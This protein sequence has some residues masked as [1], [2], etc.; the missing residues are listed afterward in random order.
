MLL[1]RNE[2][3]KKQKNLP[4]AVDEAVHQIMSEMSLKDRTALANMAEDK[5]QFLQLTL[6][7]YIK[8]KLD[9]WGVNGQLMKSCRTISKDETLTEADASTVIMK[10][11]WKNLRETHKLRVVK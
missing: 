9:E 1:S 6:G 4:R 8:N 7:L 3:L 11:L 2:R 10:E 5:L